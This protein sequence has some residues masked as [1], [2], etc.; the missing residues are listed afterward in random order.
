MDSEGILTQ[1]VHQLRPLEQLIDDY[2]RSEVGQGL[3]Y[4]RVK[5]KVEALLDRY[6]H[7]RRIKSDGNCFYRAVGF[8]YFEQV[9]IRG[10]NAIK[11]LL[12]LYVQPPIQ[13]ASGAMKDCTTLGR[14]AMD[15]VPPW[16]RSLSP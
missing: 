6:S 4:Q 1:S 14:K 12:G 7:I 16:E 13:V 5:P 15:S 3:S 8:G 9:I 11:E 10:S 2:K